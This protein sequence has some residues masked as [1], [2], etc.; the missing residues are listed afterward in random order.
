M[1]RIILITLLFGGYLFGSGSAGETDILWRTINFAIFIAILYYLLANPIKN[2]FTGRSK[3][4]SDDLERVQE[5]LR[6]SKRLKELAK[7][8]VDEAKVFAS[9]LMESSKKENK[10]IFDRIIAQG[11]ADIDVISKQH[12]SLMDLE[13]RQMVRDVVSSVMGN[14]TKNATDA[15]GKDAMADIL[16]K[17]VA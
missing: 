12:S 10:I 15:M 8:K 9:E 13:Q 16:K 11:D 4:I 2:Y 17:K 14:V 6:E 1:G 7:Q 3:S 5:R